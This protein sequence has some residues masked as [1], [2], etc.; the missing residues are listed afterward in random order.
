ML[1]DERTRFEA[2]Y[3]E[4]VREMRPYSLSL[5]ALVAACA[6]SAAAC[7]GGNSTPDTWAIGFHNVHGLRATLRLDKSLARSNTCT[8]ASTSGSSR[9]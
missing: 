1:T 9:T 5:L 6:L 8:G 4:H 7:S 2:I 3:R